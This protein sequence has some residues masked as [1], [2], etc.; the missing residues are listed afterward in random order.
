MSVTTM[1]APRAQ[2]LP[3][4]ARRGSAERLAVGLGWF[5][6]GLGALELLAAEPL[7]RRL[8]MRGQESL[9][10]A[11]GLREIA[12]GIGLLTARDR[13]PWVWARV[14]GDAL[15]LATLAAEV[16]GNRHPGGLGMAFAAVLGVT[17]IDLICAESLRTE[18]TDR[19]R[20]EEAVRKYATRSG[21]PRSPEQMRGAARDFEVPRDF[22]TPE[23]LRPWTATAQGAV[24]A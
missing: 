20:T 15:D 1:D 10:R 21:L 16:R 11:Y 22:R 2:R 24:G 4:P 12:T 6:L 17:A 19:A 23:A 18:V 13:R 7:A 14:G 5:S 3:R 9:L 8:G